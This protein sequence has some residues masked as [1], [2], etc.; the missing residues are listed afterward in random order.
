MLPGNFILAVFDVEAKLYVP[1]LLLFLGAN[2][3]ISNATLHKRKK[4]FQTL[5]VAEKASLQIT[6]NQLHDRMQALLEAQKIYI[7]GVASL[8]A[9]FVDE[10][11]CHTGKK[12]DDLR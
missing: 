7:P 10:S 6:S 12:H 8:Q 9:H 11:A 2:Q 5:T 3:E 1:G 4:R